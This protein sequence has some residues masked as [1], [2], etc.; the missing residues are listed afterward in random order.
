MLTKR[1]TSYIHLYCTAKLNQDH[2]LETQA[3]G[4]MSQS[5]RDWQTRDHLPAEDPVHWSLTRL[6][7]LGTEAQWEREEG[8]LHLKHLPPWRTI[9]FISMWDVYCSACCVSSTWTESW[10]PKG[11]WSAVPRAWFYALRGKKIRKHFA[12]YFALSIAVE[13]SATLVWLV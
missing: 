8:S 2:T 7:C 11:L 6:R 13:M 10:I 4:Q 9:F 12:E 5:H 3:E 1:S